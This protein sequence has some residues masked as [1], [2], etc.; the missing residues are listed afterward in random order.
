[1]GTKAYTGK[2]KTNSTVKLPPQ[3]GLN[4]AALENR[5][6]SHLTELSH[7]LIASLNLYDFKSLALLILE[8]IKV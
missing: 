1:M 6:N 7:H 5:V 4:P 3:W 8:I 2:N